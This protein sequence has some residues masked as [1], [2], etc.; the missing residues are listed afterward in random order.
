MKPHAF[1]AV[2]C[3]KVILILH[4]LLKSLG[5]NNN[6]SSS[7][8]FPFKPTGTKQNIFSSDTFPLKPTGGNKQNTKIFLTKWRILQS[9]GLL[10]A[11]HSMGQ[12]ADV[13]LRPAPRC[14]LHGEE[15]GHQRPGCLLKGNDL[16]RPLAAMHAYYITHT[17]I[18]IYIYVYIYILYHILF[19]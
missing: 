5:T 7:D 18:C 4:H 12:D 16:P 19:V 10:R 2:P 6:M 15:F 14:Q 13:H 11:A 1:G 9:P 8:T 3:E 17:S